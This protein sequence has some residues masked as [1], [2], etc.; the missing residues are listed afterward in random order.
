MESTNEYVQNLPTA[1]VQ[2]F[3]SQQ[4]WRTNN[5]LYTNTSSNRKWLYNQQQ[6]FKY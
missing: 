4:N 1:T 6:I 3:I 5:E 2:N